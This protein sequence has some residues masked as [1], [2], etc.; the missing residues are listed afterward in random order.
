MI[1][2]IFIFAFLTFHYTCVTCNV[3]LVFHIGGFQQ[4]VSHPHHVT[5]TIVRIPGN[6]QL[7]VVRGTRYCFRENPQTVI[8]YSKVKYSPTGHS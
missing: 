8:C 3:L 5:V 4:P 1:L 7:R 2:Q 6:P